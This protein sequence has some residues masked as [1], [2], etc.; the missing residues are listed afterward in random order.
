LWPGQL[1][2]LA[3]LGALGH[4]DLDLVR[5]DEVV[6]VD[7]EAAG[8]DLLDRGAAGVPV[9]V[10][11]VADGV[12]PALARVRLAA[13]AVHRDGQR[14]VGLARERAERHGARREA[15]DDLRR[16]LD[17][18]EIDPA[19]LREAEAQ[20]AP[21]RRPAR[22]V[23]VDQPRVLRVGLGAAVA[24]RVL[25][26]RDRL[27]VPLVVLAVAAPGVHAA[28]GQEV[29]VGPRVG[30]RVLVERLAGE[31]LEAD[32]ADPRRRA[33]EVR[34]DELGR[35]ADRLEDLGA[36]VGVDRRDAHLGDRL[37]QALGDAP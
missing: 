17:L 23:L 34:L 35:Q 33:G 21:Q 25:Q 31:R 19:P 7:P 15:L 5:V 11:G 36:V 4:L 6:D 29:G 22:G 37:E 3:G 12:L 2:A 20:Q 9:G 18:L 27:R 24:H 16:R 1:A 32:A 30:A 28:H 8:R 14:L 13:E 26:E 10:G